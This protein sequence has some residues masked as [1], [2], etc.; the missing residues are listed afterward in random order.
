[1][2]GVCI[3]LNPLLLGRSEPIRSVRLLEINF[4][5][6]AHR[7]MWGYAPEHR[8]MTTRIYQGTNQAHGDGRRLQC[9]LVGLRC[10]TPDP[11]GG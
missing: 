7:A 8:A 10:A 9:R 11:D 6:V 5:A 1:M 3:R 2:P 4:G